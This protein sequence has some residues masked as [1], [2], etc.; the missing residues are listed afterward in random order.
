MVFSK[1]GYGANILNVKMDWPCNNNFS[2]DEQ[3]KNS[4]KKNKE[5]IF[6]LRHSLHTLFSTGMLSETRIY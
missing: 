1:E 2:D 4:R 6:I 3:V 5:Q